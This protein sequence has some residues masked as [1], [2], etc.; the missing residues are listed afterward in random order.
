[1]LSHDY[2]GNYLEWRY[3][4]AANAYVD[5]RPDAET[6]VQYRTILRLE[7]GWQA[8]LAS[9][10]PHVVLWS[11]DSP[12]VEQLAADDDWVEATRQGDYTVFCR[13]D[14]AD[15]CR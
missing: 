4:T 3:G 9:V 7:E 15:R 6:L 12:L 8:E 14:L 5:D 2:V 10:D 13:A 1:V 11:T